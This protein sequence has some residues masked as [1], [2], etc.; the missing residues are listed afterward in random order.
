[1]FGLVTSTDWTRKTNPVKIDGSEGDYVGE[2][3]KEGVPNGF[4]IC[5]NQEAGIVEGYSDN[6][7]PSGYVNWIVKLGDK[8]MTSRVFFLDGE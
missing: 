4:G 1:M 8:I 3:N 7:K 6:E 2:V 5:F